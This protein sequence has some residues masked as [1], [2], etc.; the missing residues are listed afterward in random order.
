M[1]VCRVPLRACCV[2]CVCRAQ[3]ELLLNCTVADPDALR[4]NLRAEAAALSREYDHAADG[5]SLADGAPLVVEPATWRN[6]VPTQSKEAYKARFLQNAAATVGV[7]SIAGLPIATPVA[8]PL[9]HAGCVG[10]CAVAV[11][12]PVAMPVAAPVD[13]G[14]A[15]PTSFRPMVVVEGVGVK[16][17]RR[18]L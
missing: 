15:M 10:E 17:A 8:A 7:G 6:L 9:N 18:E 3:L 2:L 14:G 5:A 1:L 13:N 12:V 16:R 4:S 11:A